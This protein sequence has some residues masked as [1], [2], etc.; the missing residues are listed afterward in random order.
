[1]HIELAWPTLWPF[2]QLAMRGSDEKPSPAEI[3]ASIRANALQGWLVYDKTIAVAG[4]CTKLI[5]D[6]TSGE[7]QCHIWLI[8]GSHLSLW[9]EDFLSKLITWAKSEGCSAITACSSRCWGRRPA[10]Y[11]FEPIEERN[12]FPTWRRAI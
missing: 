1:M 3:L 6:Q 4:I 7:L 5:R 10:R 2:L 12:G 11:G 9:A 8:A